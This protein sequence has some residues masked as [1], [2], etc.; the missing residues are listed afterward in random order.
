VRHRLP[1]LIAAGTTATALAAAGRAL[2]PPE[3]AVPILLGLTALAVAA[4]LT[5][6]RRPPG[7]AP[8]RYAELLEILLVLACVPVLCAVL[9]LFGLVRGLG[10]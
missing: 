3:L 9:Q 8:A 5:Y 1:L 4:A 6:S 10:G 2:H 7:A